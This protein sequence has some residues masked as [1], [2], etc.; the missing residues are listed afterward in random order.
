M[1]WHGVRLRSPRVWPR[2]ACGSELS[3][4]SSTRN[5]DCGVCLALFDWCWH[6][7][8]LGTI[9]SCVPCSCLTDY[10]A[11]AA[12][13][14]HVL[15][16]TADGSFLPR[17]PPLRV[18]HRYPDMERRGLFNRLSGIWLIAVITISNAW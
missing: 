9:W 6:P 13:L 7:M 1:A 3:S 2:K 4:V 5:P 17:S 12:E 8:H 16:L 14:L 11:V 10:V 15:N 18:V